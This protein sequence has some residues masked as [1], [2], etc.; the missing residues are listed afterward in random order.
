LNSPDKSEKPKSRRTPVRRM[1]PSG[2]PT[3]HLILDTA[4]QIL[5]EQ[6]YAA[7]NARHIAERAGIKRQLVYYYF[8]DN[9]DLFVQLFDRVADQ[10]LDKMRAA[11]ESENPLRETWDGGVI[12]NDATIMA[13]FAVLANRSEPVRAAIM[14]YIAAA[15]DIQVAALAKAFD[16]RKL[17]N[18]DLPPIAIAILASS[19]ALTLNRE[20]G[21]G[22]TKGHEEVRRVIEQ[23]LEQAES[24]G[25]RRRRPPR[26]TTS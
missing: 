20:A 10:L 12:T 21:L 6:G 5:Q 16:G 1:G 13:E 14:K 4:E 17:P 11:L 8:Q 3:W 25:G 9:D 23:F 24:G 26:T 7:L 18:V 22:F 2:S 15:R 19:V